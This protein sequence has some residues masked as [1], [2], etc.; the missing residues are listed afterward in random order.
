MTS[1]ADPP[2]ARASHLGRRAVVERLLLPLGQG[3]GHA[4]WRPPPRCL[5][6]FARWGIHH[7]DRVSA[8]RTDSR[9]RYERSR[10]RPGSANTASRLG[11]PA[12]V[13]CCPRPSRAAGARARHVAPAAPLVPQERDRRARPQPTDDVRA[14]RG[15]PAAHRTAPLWV[16]V[17]GHPQAWPAARRDEPRRRRAGV[18]RNGVPA[19]G[20]RPRR[21][22]PRLAPR[23]VA[24]D[25]G[26][27]TRAPPRAAPCR[28]RQVARQ[29]RRAER[30][31][32]GG[33]PPPRWPRW[34]ARAR[35]VPHTQPP[36]VPVS[37][38]RAPQTPR[39]AALLPRK[40]KE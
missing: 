23:P 13:R 33:G 24:A 17:A 5:H 6:R 32:G 14:R 36:Q 30:T 19:V 38:Q 15:G 18:G 39:P 16:H 40:T 12:S 20:R 1:A 34:W 8:I 25:G 22:G 21:G 35:E 31:R 37:P 11:V 4:Q 27:A 29:R 10:G 2:S 9:P 28:R 3:I 26:D 7:P